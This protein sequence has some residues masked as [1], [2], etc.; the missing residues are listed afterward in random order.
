[1]KLWLAGVVFPRID[2]ALNFDSAAEAGS[3][4]PSHS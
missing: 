2:R 1:M 3:V 4:D